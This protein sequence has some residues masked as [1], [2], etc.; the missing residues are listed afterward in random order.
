MKTPGIEGGGDPESLSLMG[1]AGSSTAGPT[2]PQPQLWP[3]T[4]T[5]QLMLRGPAG[6]AL[7]AGQGERVRQERDSAHCGSETLGFIEDVA[8]PLSM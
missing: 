4:H 3:L 5:F 8:N 7:A 1:G 6:P 2:R